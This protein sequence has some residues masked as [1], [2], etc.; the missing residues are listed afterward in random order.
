MSKTFTPI[1]EEEKQRLFYALCLSLVKLKDIGE[2]A[3]LLQDLFTPQEAEMMARRLK[4]AG[5]LLEEKSYEEIRKDLGSGYTTIARVAEWLRLSGD[6]Y[7]KAV[8]KMRKGNNKFST[9]QEIRMKRQMMMERRAEDMGSMK[10]RYPMY[11]W[12]QVVLENIVEGSTK[13]QLSRME[14]MLKQME[15]AK[16]KPEVYDRLK[17]LLFKRRQE[18]NFAHK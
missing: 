7:R 15:K 6:G 14:S 4:I 13:R 18:V 2:A 11:Y 9:K 1:S 17:K 8:D 3:E 16:K 5:L 12:P 10:R